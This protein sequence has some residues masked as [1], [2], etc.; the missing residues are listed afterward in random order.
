MCKHVEEKVCTKNVCGGEGEEGGE[1]HTREKKIGAA[2]KKYEGGYE[3][4]KDRII[5]KY[6]LT[7]SVL[8]MSK[9]T[10]SAAMAEVAFE[11]RADISLTTWRRTFPNG[12]S[13]TPTVVFIRDI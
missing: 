1:W 12:G 8:N 3:A 4:K 7:M 13:S 6:F 5:V 10:I 9:T 2:D 11:R